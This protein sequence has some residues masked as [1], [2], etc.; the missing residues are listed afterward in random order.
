MELLSYSLGIGN[1]NPLVSS[2]M[3]SSLR[4]KKQAGSVQEVGLGLK[5]RLVFQVRVPSDKSHYC[6]QPQHRHQALLS[7]LSQVNSLIY[8]EKHCGSLIWPV[9]WCLGGFVVLMVV[10][11]AQ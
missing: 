1:C 10:F 9:K 5:A 3:E 11:G 6:T 4:K 7:F 2:F 8:F